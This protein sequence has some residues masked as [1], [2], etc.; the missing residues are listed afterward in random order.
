MR[1]AAKVRINDLQEISM[2]TN[3]IMEPS[4]CDFQ[5]IKVTITSR[6]PTHRTSRHG[7]KMEILA[8]I[9]NTV[10]ALPK[11]YLPPPIS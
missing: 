9:S 10:L 3:K 8:A 7:L 4:D 5:V 6:I 2:K 1:N 11:S